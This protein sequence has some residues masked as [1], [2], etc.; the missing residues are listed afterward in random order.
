MMSSLAAGGGA[1]ADALIDRAI[2]GRRILY[3]ARGDRAGFTV[4]PVLWPGSTRVRLTLN[5]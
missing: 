5:W 4:R 2:D 3:D 1:L